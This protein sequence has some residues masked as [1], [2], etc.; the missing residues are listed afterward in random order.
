MP[1]AREA[2]AFYQQSLEIF[3][4]IQSADADEED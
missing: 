4:R 2:I 3:Q 1:A